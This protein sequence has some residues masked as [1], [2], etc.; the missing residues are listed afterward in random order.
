MTTR[1]IP[2]DHWR[3]ELDSFSRQHEGWIVTVEVTESGET[4]TEAHDV[5]L[6]GVS[7]DNPRQDAIAVIVGHEPKD[8]VTHEVSHPV[9]VAIEQ[10][11]GGAERALR[12]DASDGST[13]TVEFRSPMRPEQVDGVPSR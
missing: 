7:V 10:T 8:H 13:T 5:P 3:E 9:T 11:D 1:E 4:R 12:I 6:Y 2:R